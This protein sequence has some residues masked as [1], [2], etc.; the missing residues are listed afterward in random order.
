MKLVQLVLFLMFSV[1]TYCLTAQANVEGEPKASETSNS[2]TIKEGGP[3][4]TFDNP[5]MNIGE[6]KR[7]DKKA[8]EFHF[9]N[10]GTEDLKIEIVSGCEC[11]T[12]DWPRLPIKPGESGII[13]A[14]FDSTEKE[15]SEIV[16]IDINLENLDEEGYPM[17]VRVQYAFELVE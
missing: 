15:K 5:Q 11:T 9:T 8:M 10:T 12:L 17:F 4:M 13:S 2:N 7:G 14:L 3:S 1:F 6:I 16:D